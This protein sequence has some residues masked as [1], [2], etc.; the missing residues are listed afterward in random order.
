VATS[1]SRRGGGGGGY[2]AGTRRRRHRGEG[3]EVESEDG[4]AI[5]GLLLK[6]SD[7][8]IAIY[9]LRQMKHASQTLA[10]TPEN[11]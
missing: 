7:A 8:T 5:P 4:D 1:A 3:E 6:H 11:I 10:K 9:I 2:P